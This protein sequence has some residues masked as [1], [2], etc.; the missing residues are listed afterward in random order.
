MVVVVVVVAVV[1]VEDAV[2]LDVGIAE[3]VGEAVL[4]DTAPL[5]P[6][7]QVPDSSPRAA[8]VS[9]FLIRTAA[10]LDTPSTPVGVPVTGKMTTG[11]E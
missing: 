7:S 6:V 1:V 5:P 8:K 10:L 2:V 9:M 3:V 4:P 11:L